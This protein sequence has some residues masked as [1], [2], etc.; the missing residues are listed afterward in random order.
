MKQQNLPIDPVVLGKGLADA[1]SGTPMCSQEQVAQIMAVFQ[2]E[3]A[4][5]QEKMTQAKASENLAKS[6]KF[7]DDNK[8]L[9]GVMTTPSGLQYKVIK[10]GSG[11]KPVHESTVKV[12]YTG[13]LANGE[14]FDSSVERGEPIEFA[15]SGVIPGWTEGLQLM[16]VGSKYMLYIPPSL[17]YGEAGAGGRIGPNEALVFEVELLDIVA[18]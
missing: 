18:K 11:R 1:F 12:H 8:K 17:G 2:Q 4:A 9:P 6:Q 7:L 16:T 5:Q 10:E 13:R 3:M 15:L 14:V